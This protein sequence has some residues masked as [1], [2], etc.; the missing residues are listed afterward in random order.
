MGTTNF[1]LARI[2]LLNIQNMGLLTCAQVQAH[3]QMK[4]VGVKA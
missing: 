4:V 3:I 2:T 1:E